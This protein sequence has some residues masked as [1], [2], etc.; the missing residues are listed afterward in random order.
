MHSGKE[1]SSQLPSSARSNKIISISY[2]DLG[3][4]C[5]AT[6][7]VPHRTPKRWD[8][9]SSIVCDCASEQNESPIIRLQETDG[10][11]VTVFDKSSSCCKEAVRIIVSKYKQIFEDPES[12]LQ[13]S[14][15]TFDTRTALKRIILLPPVKECCNEL[16]VIRNRPSFPLV[17]TQHGTF[18]AALFSGECRK[19]CSKKYSHSYYQVGDKLHYYNPSDSDYFHISSQTIFSTSLLDDVTNNIAIS[20]TSFQSRAEV[21]N[22]NFRVVDHHCMSKLT[23]FGR[24][25]SDHEHPWKL[26]EKR[27]EDAWFMYALVNFYCT[28]KLLGN[29]DF[30]TEAS[31]SQRSDIDELCGSAWDVIIE[32]TNPWIHH[33]CEMKGCIEG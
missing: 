16:L 30:H 18:V 1:C 17:Y 9:I 24:S 3:I 23:N 22:E 28:K 4:L 32:D 15:L 8:L 13:D 14:L 5:A 20:A 10:D 27:I 26:N 31:P 12:L 29:T 33:K 6:K 2:R 7:H 19:G 21:Y 25:L 11:N